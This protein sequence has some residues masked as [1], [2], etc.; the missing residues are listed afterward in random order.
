MIKAI[1]FDLYGVLVAEGFRLF[2]DTYFPGD[3]TKRQ[4]A[5]D[6]V[7]SHD[8]GMISKPQYISG[9]AELAG[10]SQ[11]IVNEHMTSN[12]PNKPLI[13]LVRNQ[14]KPKYKLG[15]LSNSGDDYINQMLEPKDIELFDD[16]LLSYR[17]GLV[18]PQ[19][20]IFDLAA[21]RLGVLS[22]ECLFIDDSMTHTQ[23]AQRT[24]MK[25]ILYSD[26]PRF[27]SELEVIL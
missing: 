22:T 15:V 9:L 1:I 26:F 6:L 13:E 23:G 11:E 8:A 20:E 2:C 16:V 12:R 18:K 3:K 7:T 19:A 14:L 17:I 21:E 10:V 27:K 25:T 24:G 5:L 4:T